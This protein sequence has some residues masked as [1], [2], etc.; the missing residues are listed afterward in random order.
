MDVMITIIV[1]TERAEYKYSLSR[2]NCMLIVNSEII[3]IEIIEYNPI[4]A[5]VG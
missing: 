5:T 4:M 3:G 2:S 1:S